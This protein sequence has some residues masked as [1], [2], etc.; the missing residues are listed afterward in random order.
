MAVVNSYRVV[1]ALIKPPSAPSGNGRE[2][3]GGEEETPTGDEGPKRSVKDDEP[4]DVAAEVRRFSAAS[5]SIVEKSKKGE[6]ITH[7]TVTAA[8]AGVDEKA[9]EERGDDEKTTGQ[10]RVSEGRE[11][12]DEPGIGED[13]HMREERD[14]EGNR[15][16][17]DDEQKCLSET[18]RQQDDGQSM[19][20]RV[21]KVKRRRKSKRPEESA[22]DDLK[23][24]AMKELREKR[25][26]WQLKLQ[27]EQADPGR[28]VRIASVVHSQQ[29]W[30]AGDTE[31]RGWER[32]S[33]GLLL[34]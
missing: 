12:E 21:R 1:E 3:N 7:S 24:A 27:Q 11:G 34:V 30:G 31:P 14:K 6:R 28:E 19:I 26:R 8:L 25:R 9:G 15:E 32:S 10:G 2:D 17:E 18:H 20:G 29:R 4:R 13:G 5:A 22:E 23:E 33:I 16:E